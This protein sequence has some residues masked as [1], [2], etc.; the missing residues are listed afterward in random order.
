MTGLATWEEGELLQQTLRDIEGA[1]YNAMWGV[2]NTRRHGVPHNRPR[3]Y[4]VAL[5][6]D[7]I[8]QQFVF[9]HNIHCPPL[10]DFICDRRCDGQCYPTTAASATACS[11]LANAAAR[12]RDADL[13]EWAIDI[14]QPAKRGLQ[15]CPCPWLPYLAC[16]RPRS[17]WLGARCRYGS[18]NETVRL[19][20]FDPARL[21]LQAD[22]GEC[23]AMLGDAM[24]V[25]A[26]ERIL[27]GALAAAGILTGEDRWERG[28]P[29]HISA[30]TQPPIPT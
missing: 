20:G 6:Q 2:M 23:V 21:K 24:S 17:M 28:R 19:Q 26:I 1:G 3:L 11:I 16:T 10:R 4:V 5:R 22:Q 12:A 29:R 14:E 13:D 8:S 30:G 18:L 15:A 9:P 27:H 25:N 7:A